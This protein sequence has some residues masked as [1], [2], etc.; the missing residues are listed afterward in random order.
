MSSFVIDNL[1][2]RGV[3]HDLNVNSVNVK[4]F[5]NLPKIDVTVQNPRALK[6]ILV[7]DI[8][9]HCLYYSI[10]DPE[11]KW[12]KI[13][14]ASASTVRSF[15]FATQ[16][17]STAVTIGFAGAIST[18][19]VWLT[20]TPVMTDIQL[21]NNSTNMTVGNG[22]FSIDVGA[23][24]GADASGSYILDWSA[25]INTNSNGVA[26]D[27]IEFGF[28]VDGVNSGLPTS[29]AGSMINNSSVG[30]PH[31]QHVSGISQLDLSV[32]DSVRFYTRRTSGAN[33]GAN[34]T[35]VQQ[36]IRITRVHQ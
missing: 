8:N 7:Q 24:V 23:I 32:G 28:G 22:G 31:P 3:Q 12:I 25:S 13:G 18:G 33:L 34:I 20:G 10:S 15:A 6:G 17:P 35:V 19:Q 2:N 5:L 9:D 11:Y 14:Q 36:N 29:T 26:D 30:T 1:A 16:N 27:T 4:N 21:I